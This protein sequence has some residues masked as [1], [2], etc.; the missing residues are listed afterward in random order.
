M[1]YTF[2]CKKQNCKLD[3]EIALPL[4]IYEKFQKMD[5]PYYE[6]KCPR[7]FT[8]APERS[9]PPGSVAT[10]HTENGT[11]DPRTAPTPLAGKHYTSKEEKER[12]I[13]A[14][15]GDSYGVMDHSHD[16]TR[17]PTR[18]ADYSVTAK[19]AV[20]TKTLVATK[21]Q[22]LAALPRGTAFRLSSFIK[23]TG[24]NKSTVRYHLIK[25][26][27]TKPEPGWFLVPA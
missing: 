20:A 23:D 9:F 21:D 6:V 26:E 17:E 4:A 18:R 16:K 3:F 2:Q 1:L 15:L 13:G 14:V 7:C 8:K 10:V 19:D 25:L 27:A 22:I 5:P 11:W 24:F 12:Q